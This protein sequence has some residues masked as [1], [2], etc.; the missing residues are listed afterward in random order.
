VLLTR[1]TIEREEFL[2]L[3]AGASE[4]DVYRSKDEDARR[5]R[6]IDEGAAPASES[7]VRMPFPPPAPGPP[8]PES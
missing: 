3:L 4:E 6:T 5:Q 7:P 1:E 2:A 8:I